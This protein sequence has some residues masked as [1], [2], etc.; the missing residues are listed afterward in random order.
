[1]ETSP[2]SYKSRRQL[3]LGLSSSQ[4]PLLPLPQPQ[5]FFFFLQHWHANHAVLTSFL[6]SQ[7]FWNILFSTV[8]S[9]GGVPHWGSTVYSVNCVSAR[10]PPPAPPSPVCLLEYE[11][12][13]S[14]G[15]SLEKCGNFPISL[16][17]SYKITFACPRGDRNG[18][19]FHPFYGAVPTLMAKC[20]L[21][22]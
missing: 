16:V 11:F 5:T 14:F 13:H 17:L 12:M 20:C 22:C 2:G 4:C 9:F 8:N 18:N 21:C 1:M 6:F 7:F 15:R 19:L 3:N 10:S